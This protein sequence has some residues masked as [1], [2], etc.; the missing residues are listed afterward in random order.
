MSVKIK[1]L[2]QLQRKLDELQRKVEKVGGVRS[3]PIDEFLTST[4]LS[5]FTNFTSLEE[6][7]EKS[8]YT[9]VT[10]EDFD[11]IPQDEWDAF[12]ARNTLFSSW[13][14]ILNHAAAERI[15]QQLDM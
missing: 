14:D 8:G 6:L 7:F 4:F 11:Q 12:I 5:R 1:G 2:D 3:V 10:Q 15:K 9:V 13:Q